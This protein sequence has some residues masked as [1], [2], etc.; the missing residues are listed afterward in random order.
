MRAVR[1]VLVLLDNLTNEDAK[2]RKCRDVSIS[3]VS[4]S[5]VQAVVA[6]MKAGKKKDSGIS[7]F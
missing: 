5:V 6:R 7:D 2:I 3:D 1:R 4:I